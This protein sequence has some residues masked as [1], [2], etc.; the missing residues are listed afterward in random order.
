MP[1]LHSCSRIKSTLLKP[2]PQQAL[3]EWAVAINGITATIS[4][5]FFL[6]QASSR[7]LG[8]RGQQLYLSF[9]S[10]HLWCQDSAWHEAGSW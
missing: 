10:L 8:P 6:L 2:G 1:A 9:S 7:V 4:M 3:R 5:H